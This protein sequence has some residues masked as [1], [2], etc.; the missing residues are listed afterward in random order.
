MNNFIKIYFWQIVSLIF[1]F[2]SLFVV[3]PYLSTNQ[4]LYGIYTIVTSAY[5]FISYADFGFLSA[6]MKY[7]A[8]SYAQ[9]DYKSEIE[10]I[11][12][13]GSV[14]MAFV[15]LYAVFVF[16]LSFKPELLIGEVTSVTQLSKASSLL[17][18]LALFSPIFVIQRILQII[19]GVRLQD[20]KFQRILI[21]S[22]LIKVCSAYFFF[23]GGKYNLVEYFLFSQFC[24]LLAIVTGLFLAKRNLGYDLNYLLRN[25]RFSKRLYN[26]TKKLAFTSIFLTISWILYYE[27]DPFVIGKVMGASQ[28][29][30]FAVGLTIITYFR[31]LFGIFFSPFIAKFN[32]FIGVRDLEGLRKYFIKVLVL[33]LPITVFP[34]LIVFFTAKSFILTW[35]GS[36]Y[37]SSVHIAEILIMSYIF[38]FITY[39]AGILIM[40]NERVKALYLTSAVQ[41]I[42]FWFGVFFTYKYLGLESFAYFK[43]VALFL[44]MIICT[45]LVMQFLQINISKI[46]KIVLM[47]AIVPIFTICISLYLL[48]N[49]YP[50]DK[51][52]INL[53]KYVVLNIGVGF[54]GIVAYYACSFEF[55][56][57]TNNVYLSLSNKFF[58]KNEYGS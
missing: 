54:I 57:F 39:P 42:I 12:F 45:V 51:N 48:K 34:V 37:L 47:P 6:G 4:S 16:G 29:A 30:I 40:A 5:L 58:N 8:E 23:A 32:H 21:V 41:P 27:I 38:S 33:F 19:F 52:K 56:R 44:E 28:V 11:G 35:V 49:F 24:N 20:Y 53:G 15:L 9:K 13:S 36:T 46:F 26:K 55:R 10:V 17:L 18:I 22:N 2:A 1:N 50:I 7:A 25:F 3:T 43:F 14:F 31:S